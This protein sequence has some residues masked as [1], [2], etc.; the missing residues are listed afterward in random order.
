MTWFDKVEQTVQ[1]RRIE[2]DVQRTLWG[3]LGPTA[4]VVALMVPGESQKEQD[5]P[6]KLLHDDRFD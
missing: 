3:K 4:K 5:D 6:R 2:F 1:V